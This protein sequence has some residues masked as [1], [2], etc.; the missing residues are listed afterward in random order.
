MKE[1]YLWDKTGQDLEIKRLENA[2]QMF[3]YQETV[4]PALPAKILPFKKENPRR[5]FRLAFAFAACAAFVIISLSVRF[6]FSPEK[7]EVAR[8]STETIAPS[9]DKKFSDEILVKNPDDLI[10]ENVKTPKQSVKRNIVKIRKIAQTNIRQNNLTARNAAA[11]KPAVKLTKEE[12]YAYDQLML[13]LSITSEKL[14]LVS[15]KIDGVEEQTV[16]RENSR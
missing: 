12:K 2:L 6:Q 4:P 1:D 10:V 5:I 3:R 7:I 13:A 11:K 8:D 14:K 9:I 15:D 16:V